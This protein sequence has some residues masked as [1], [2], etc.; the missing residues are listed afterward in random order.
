MIKEFRRYPT[1]QQLYFTDRKPYFFIE[2]FIWLDI[3]ELPKYPSDL[4]M[5][6]NNWLTISLIGFKED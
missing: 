5:P 2:L 3:P 1:V 6:I 4:M